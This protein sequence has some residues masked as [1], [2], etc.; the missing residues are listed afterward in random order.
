[1][2][3]TS[4]PIRIP[5]TISTTTTGR[6][7][8]PLR[9]EA[10]VA[11][12]A[13]QKISASE[14]R[15]G[16]VVTAAY[17]RPDERGWPGASARA[18][19]GDLHPRDRPLARPRPRTRDRVGLL[20]RRDRE[21]QRLHGRLADPVARARVRRRRGALGRVRPRLQRARR[22]GRQGEG[23]AGRLLNLL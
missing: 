14:T 1:M 20:L 22:E 5:R 13:A 3:R 9:R 10:I 6:T 11:T 8:R 2:S 15:S 17:T 7:K 16:A 4:G 23:V 19:D 21:D 18:L 12:A